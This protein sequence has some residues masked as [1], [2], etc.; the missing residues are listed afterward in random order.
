MYT[1]SELRSRKLDEFKVK[2]ETPSG[3]VNQN[4]RWCLSHEISLFNER[5]PDLWREAS[6]QYSTW[7]SGGSW[8]RSRVWAPARS[9]R[10]RSTTGY[11][12]RLPACSYR[13]PHSPGQLFT[14]IVDR[15]RTDY[16][17]E[18][19]I[20]QNILLNRAV[21]WSSENYFNTFT[22]IYRI[23]TVHDK[24]WPLAYTHIRRY[25]RVTQTIPLGGENMQ[26]KGTRKSE[27]STK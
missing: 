7:R 6:G 25:G 18:R 13:S 24:F 10:C 16:R 5:Y 20:E 12:A 15:R 27:K 9:S 19:T 14:M 8:A 26:E 4:T 21:C 22:G 1:R 23:S 3:G 11:P 17:I 2:L